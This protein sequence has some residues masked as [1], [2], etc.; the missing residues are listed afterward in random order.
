MSD[1]VIVILDEC[2]TGGNSKATNVLKNFVTNLNLRLREMY[3]SAMEV[4]NHT[5]IYLLS[6][7]KVKIFHTMPNS[8]RWVCFDSNVENYIDWLLQDEEISN[9]AQDKIEY[10]NG[11]YAQYLQ[12][13][14]IPVFANLLY[15]INVN[16]FDPSD[17]PYTTALA[18]VQASADI[19]CLRVASAF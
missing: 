15:N 9:R 6:N 3:K 2:M 17:I 16:N 14:R 10:F 5:H 7:M 1:K 8:R 12:D 18:K 13:E 11:I 19:D 4:A